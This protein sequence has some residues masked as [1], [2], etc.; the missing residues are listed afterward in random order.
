MSFSDRAALPFLFLPSIS[1]FY[2]TSDSEEEKGGGRPYNHC[3]LCN[4]YKQNGLNGEN[5]S[6]TEQRKRRNNQRTLIIEGNS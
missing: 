2:V 5:Q 3:R 6:N 1:V 4:M